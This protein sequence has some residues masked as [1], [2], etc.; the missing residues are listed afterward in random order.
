MR[1]GEP[2]IGK[3]VLSG[4]AAE[5]RQVIRTVDASTPGVGLVPPRRAKPRAGPD[6]DLDTREHRWRW[7]DDCHVADPAAPQRPPG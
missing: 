3:I 1:R 2:E 4:Y 7:T 5:R 6:R